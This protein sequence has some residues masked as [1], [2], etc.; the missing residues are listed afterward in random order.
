MYL[1]PLLFIALPLAAAFFTVLLGVR[2]RVLGYILASVSAITLLLASLYASYFVQHLPSHIFIY[3]VGGWMPPLGITL[4]FDALS[5][6][7]LVVV[8]LISLMA[9]LYSLRYIERYTDSWKFYS[10]FLLM[11]AGLNGVIISGDLFNLYVFLEVAS[12]SA[13]ALVAFGTEAQ[14]LEASFKYAVM[15]AL[16]SLLILLGIAFLY[17]Y[18]STLN[19]AEI[20]FVL[21]GK[22]Q[23]LL[24]YFVI[25][26][27][28]AGFGL[29]AAMV[30]F[31]AW[32]PD[33]HPSA[34]APISAML[35]GVVIK[36]LGVY[37]LARIIFNVFGMSQKALLV[38]M[39][40]GTLSMVVGALMAI[41]QRDI[42][43]ML[44]YS[45]ISQ[46]GYIL[47]ALGIGT[48]L[49]VI[50]AL[51]HLINHAVA[52]SLL[53]FNSGAVEYSTHTRDMDSLGGLNKRMPVT[54]ATSFIGS[55]SIAGLPPL[56]GFWSKLLIIIAAVQA[57]HLAM[58][59]VAVIVSIITL[60]YYLKFQ[61]Q[62]FF[63]ALRGTLDKVKEAPLSMNIAAV[64]L[65]LICVGAG[66]LLV[67]SMRPILERAADVL[68]LGSGYK[69]VVMGGVR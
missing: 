64:I 61:N 12:L 9:G 66:L 48:P 59:L 34:P 36:T 18:V 22:P 52:K 43:R 33:A 4:V 19:M 2:L 69:D 54:A 5:T 23:G 38:L 40:L 56:A 45:S 28:L 26:L 3:K 10:L 47:F 53:F 50:G 21:S 65:A 49:A 32:L 24:V 8:N 68:M 51:F 41:T 7:M 63:G 31:H 20:A 1:S 11:I 42:K 39:V 60:V 6:I 25:M 15:G 17:S 62:T 67:P 57:G 44:A 14:D 37:V 16:A 55:L 58:A 35:S 13:Y 30:P 46:M 29:K 27:F